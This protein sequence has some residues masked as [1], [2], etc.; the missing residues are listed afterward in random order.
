MDM[1][2]LEARQVCLFCPEHLIGDSEHVIFH[3]TEWWTV[4]NNRYPYNGARSH[5]LLV[6]SV[7]VKDIAELPAQAKDDFWNVLDWSRARWD[8]AF[9]G[10]GVRC[11]DFR[12]TGATL[13]HVH[14]HLIVGDVFDPDHE[15]IRMKF[16]AR[17]E[18]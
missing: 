9:Y 8:M 3:A 11:G 2:T 6:P 12:Y 4:T 14:V 15:P 7:H 10:L 13:E 1:K 5:V 16:S 17:S 18:A